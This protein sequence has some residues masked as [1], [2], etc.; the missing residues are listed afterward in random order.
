[1]SYTITS[2]CIECQRCQPAC[3]VGAIQ[4]DG[5]RFKIDSDRCNSCVGYYSVPQCV[6]ACPTNSGC[7]PDVHEFW[8][9]WFTKYNHLVSRLHQP[10][11]ATYWE[12]WFDTYSH[13]LTTQLRS[14]LAT[15]LNETVAL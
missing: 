3:P 2:Q 11:Q 15:R 1:M 7:I 5:T 12:Q 9:Q 10:K 14:P 8:E 13:R 6:A 4:W